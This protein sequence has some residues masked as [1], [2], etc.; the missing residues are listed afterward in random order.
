M[1][2]D[3][4]EQELRRLMDQERGARAVRRAALTPEEKQRRAIRKKK[5]KTQKLARRQNR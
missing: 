2:H 1:T 5:R 4:V 3:P